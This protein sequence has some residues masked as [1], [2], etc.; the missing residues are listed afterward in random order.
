MSTEISFHVHWNEN[1]AFGHVNNVRYFVWFES[2][3]LELFKDIG[4]WQ[5]E[6]EGV[7]RPLIAAT[8]CQY[9]RPVIAP[10]Q[11]RVQAFVTRIGNSS[12]TLGYRAYEGDAVVATG[13]SVVV[14]TSKATERPTPIPPEM[15][16]ALQRHLEEG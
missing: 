5:G 7:L 12:F 16:Q 11:V 2:C 9:K 14:I 4:V 13:D 15:R 10:T 3:R 1:D 8:Q 6:E